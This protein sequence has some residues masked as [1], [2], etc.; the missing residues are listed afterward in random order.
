MQYGMSEKFG[1]MSLEKIDNPYLSNRSSLNCSDK[2][3]TEIEEEVKNLL[4]L[5]V[6]EEKY[7]TMTVDELNTGATIIHPNVNGELPNLNLQYRINNG[8]WSDFIVGTT[9][10]ITAQPGDV[11]QWKG[12]NPNG[13]SSDYTRLNFSISDSVHLSGN[14]MS[15]IDGVGE[16][17]IIPNELCFYELFKDS[18][19]KTVSEDFLPAMTLQEECYRDLF[20]S[21]HNLTQAPAL[22]ATE[23]APLLRYFA[24]LNPHNNGFSQLSLLKFYKI[25][26]D[27]IKKS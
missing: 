16:A 22:P 15:L 9:A 3:A 20:S 27:C 23:L 21:C 7:L 13:V 2:T 5:V 18:M 10:D 12:N 8:P 11:I 4:K 1:L 14:I 24:L 26:C 19:V 17:K 6:S 25:I